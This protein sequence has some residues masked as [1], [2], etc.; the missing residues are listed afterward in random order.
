M[1]ARASLTADGVH[2]PMRIALLGTSSKTSPLELRERLAFS[3][4]ELG[5]ALDAMKAYVPEGAILSTCHRV[6]LYA[7]APSLRPVR[8]ALKRFWSEQHGVSLHDLDSHLY[9]L[10][11][12][13]AVAH[14][15]SV[16]GGM[17]SAIV[18][19]PQILGQV[20]DALEQSLAHHATGSTLAALVRHAVTVGKRIRTETGISRNAASI[21]SAAVELARDTFGDLR[22]ARVLLVGTGKMGEMA[23]RNL[24]NKG[25]AGL[26][27][28]G[29]TPSRTR[30]LALECGSAVAL[31]ELE[32]ALPRCDIVISCT[33]APHWV[34]GREMVERAMRGRAGQPLFLI[35]I[36]VPRDIDPTAGGVEGVRLF[37]IDDLEATVAANVRERQAEA[38]KV[39]AIIDEEVAAFQAWLVARR[40][41]P[42]IV[43]LHQRAE[44]IRQAELARTSSVLARLPEGD[45]RR[46][47]ALT[48]AFQKKLLHQ[49]IA[50]LRAEAVAGNGRGTDR[51]V[52]QL[53]AL[54]TE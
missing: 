14:L 8:A 20:R 54:D 37:N 30:Q 7:A 1:T 46:I 16:A 26:A 4:H 9:Y 12:E 25:V 19:E 3:P 41:V 34:I 49:S 18:G 31:A 17:D 5:P 28:A 39:T 42:T 44:S 11:D 10:E 29:R 40:A 23:A 36:A 43:A 45:R 51:A 32:D 2:G 24:L 33:S 47:E 48:L 22:S 50:L 6:E 27:V 35:D 21:S 53:F 13:Q 52:R 38:P 15:F